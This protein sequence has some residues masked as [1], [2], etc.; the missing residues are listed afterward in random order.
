M[1]LLVDKLATE[2][3]RISKIIDALRKA[4]AAG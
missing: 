4:A 3:N 2:V 1:L